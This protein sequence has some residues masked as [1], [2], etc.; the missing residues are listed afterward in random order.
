MGQ[1]RVLSSLIRPFL[2]HFAHRMDI[3]CFL[4]DFSVKKM[5]RL[6]SNRFENVFENV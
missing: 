4:T 2:P 1:R 6:N 5:S 3:R